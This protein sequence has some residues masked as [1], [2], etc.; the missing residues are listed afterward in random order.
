MDLIWKS[1]ILTFLL[2][3]ESGNNFFFFLEVGLVCQEKTV[4]CE[5]SLQMHWWNG[6]DPVWEQESSWTW[7]EMVKNDMKMT[8]EQWPKMMAEWGGQMTAG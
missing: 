6:E 7:S 5:L 3:L 1:Y 8:A 2:K 4:E